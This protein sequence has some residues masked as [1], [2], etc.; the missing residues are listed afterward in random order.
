MAIAAVNASTRPST[1]I[2]SSRGSETGA[3]VASPSHGHHRRAARRQSRR[4]RSAGSSRSAADGRCGRG[5]RPRT[6]RSAS[7]RCRV[8]ERASSR[9][10]TFAQAMS[11]TKATAAE[12]HEQRRA[13]VA[14][15]RVAAAARPRS[16]RRRSR[17]GC[18]LRICSRIVFISAVASA[19]RDARASAARS[20]AGAGS[21]GTTN[22][23]SGRTRSAPRAPR[24]R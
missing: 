12:Q 15:E 17:S 23:L 2:R 18:S 7:S 13:H 19:T 14:G 16:C 6:A 4:R 1:A 20:R 21:R 11:R 5:P 24:R 9:F 8:T 10:A 3:S 22:R